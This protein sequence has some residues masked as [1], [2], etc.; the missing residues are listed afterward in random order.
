MSGAIPGLLVLASI[1]KQAEQAIGSNPVRSTPPWPLHHLLP[2]G[3]FPVS[4]PLLT[5]FGDGQ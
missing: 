3:F 1:R 2:P 5:S 4:V